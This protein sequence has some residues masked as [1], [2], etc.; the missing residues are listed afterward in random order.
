MS[1]RGLQAIIGLAVTDR[2]FREALLSQPL[3]ALE[4]FDLSDEELAVVASIR[5]KTL[6]RFAARLELR[7]SKL[8]VKRGRCD[9]P[10]APLAN[11]LRRIAR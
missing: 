7:L 4:G 5:A 6:E 3:V 10:P 1:P 9:S 11:D 2:E 8:P